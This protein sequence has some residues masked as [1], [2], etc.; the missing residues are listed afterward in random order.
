MTEAQVRALAAEVG[1][2]IGKSRVRTP[3]KPGHGL[4]RVRGSWVDREPNLAKAGNPSAP[5]WRAIVRQ[6]EWTGYLFTLAMIRI[7]V[8]DAT[9]WRTPAGPGPLLLR[10]DGTGWSSA[11]TYAVRTRW[12]CTYRGRRD[13]AE[14]AR[15]ARVSEPVAVRVRPEVAETLNALATET[16][17]S[18][19]VSDGMG[20]WIPDGNHPVLLGH[21]PRGEGWSQCG[22][23]VRIEGPANATGQCSVCGARMNREEWAEEIA[24]WLSRPMDDVRA[25][26]S[27]AAAA[28]R[29][30]VK[31]VTRAE[32]QPARDAGLRARHAAKLGRRAEA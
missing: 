17:A 11:P 12:T 27:R 23:T 19:F 16:G 10:P 30:A 32:L 20:G 21:C 29:S 9:R 22:G 26:A 14:A 6:G 7:C 24:R 1:V 25:E 5:A 8:D 28:R 18:R 13:A 4:Y 31:G 15:E 3:G 2:E